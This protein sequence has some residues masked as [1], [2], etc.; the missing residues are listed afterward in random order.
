MLNVDLVL[1]INTMSSERLHCVIG[2]LVA[3]FFISTALGL[4]VAVPGA[5]FDV[6]ALLT[7]AKWPVAPA[8]VA[9]CLLWL[10]VGCAVM[11]GYL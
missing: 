9:V 3:A 5:V 6:P 4:V 2:N 1:R 10:G 8:Y 11:V 7:M